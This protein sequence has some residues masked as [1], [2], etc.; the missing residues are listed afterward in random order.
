MANTEPA[1]K[2]KNRVLPDDYG[3]AIH[4]W[5]GWLR[6]RTLAT[7]ELHATEPGS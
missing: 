4:P 2:H 7:I 6:M 3:N 1:F 5:D